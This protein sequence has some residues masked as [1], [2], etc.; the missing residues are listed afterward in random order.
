MP[1]P[2]V[3]CWNVNGI[4]SN[5]LGVL[6]EHLK[7]KPVD[8][9]CLQET[10]L[11]DVACDS[12][13]I[14]GY[15]GYFSVS[16]SEHKARRAYAGVAVFVRDE[17]VK[18]VKRVSIDFDPENPHVPNEGRFLAIETDDVVVATVYVPNSG[19]NMKFRAETWHPDIKKWVTGIKKRLILC[20]DFN[21]VLGAYDAWWGK[22]PDGVSVSAFHERVLANKADTPGIMPYEITALKDLIKSAGLIDLWRFTHPGSAYDGYTWYKSELVRRQNKGWRIDYVFS[23]F[24]PNGAKCTVEGFA[25]QKASDHCPLHVSF[26]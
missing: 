13:K 20:G 14:P 16:Q 22:P 17:L 26:G 3:L 21:S 7:Q 12:I 11:T 18:G 19:T 2:S 6:E 5:V 23:N 25:T 15:T 4:R 24:I 10:K 1:P 9:V 8:F